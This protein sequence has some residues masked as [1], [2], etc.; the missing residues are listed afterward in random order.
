MP[1]AEY[2]AREDETFQ[3][4]LASNRSSSPS[5]RAMIQSLRRVPD[6]AFDWSSSRP[7]HV[8]LHVPY[9]FLATV[10]AGLVVLVKPKPRLRFQLW[11]ALLAVT[12]VVLSFASVAMISRA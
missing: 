9:W 6:W 2:Q 4:F 10:A 7:L 12:I 8:G 3:Q 1:L 5:A 11:Q